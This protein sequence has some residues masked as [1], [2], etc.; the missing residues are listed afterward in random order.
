MHWVPA[1]QHPDDPQG[2]PW[3]HVPDGRHADPG[4]Q[5]ALVP[6]GTLGLW[7]HTPATQPTPGGQHESPHWLP[8]AQHEPPT[9]AVPPGQHTPLHSDVGQ[10]SP[11]DFTHPPG[12]Q[13]CGRPLTPPHVFSGVQQGPAWLFRQRLAVEPQHWGGAPPGA[14]PHAYD[15]NTQLGV[16]VEV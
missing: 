1:V 8:G 14:A 9:H 7:Q 10:H 13:N 16:P 15:V 3:Q 4:E 2:V 11:V 5:H 12:Q 6:H